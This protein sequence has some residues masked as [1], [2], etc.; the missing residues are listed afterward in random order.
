MTIKLNLFVLCTFVFFSTLLLSTNNASALPANFQDTVVFSDL[1]SPT[2]ISFAPNGKVFIAE[3]A[4]IIK[5][6]DNLQDTTPTVFADL[7]SQV[8]NYSD[9]GIGGMVV[10]PQFPARPFV[11]V[12]YTMDGPIGRS[13]DRRA[14]PPS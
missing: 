14:R 10:D 9:R 7:R 3:K 12:L 1:D 2:A 4:G 13:G 11:Y 6:Y 5:V 8:H